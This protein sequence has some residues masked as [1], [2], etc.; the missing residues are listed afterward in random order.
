MLE[1]IGAS[2][3]PPNLCVITK[4]I[5]KGDLRSLLSKHNDLDWGIRISI[6]KGIARGMAYLHGM[7][8]PI[9]HRDLKGLN[10]LIDHDNTVK[11][12]DFGLSKVLPEGKTNNTNTKTGTLN[13]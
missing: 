7:Q 13:W 6:A 11:V 1:F 4:Y 5:P 3:S 10:I 12:A 2:I 9:V 8:P